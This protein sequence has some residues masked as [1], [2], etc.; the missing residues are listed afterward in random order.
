MKAEFKKSSLGKTGCGLLCVFLMQGERPPP[1]LADFETDMKSHRFEGKEEQYYHTC[2]LGKKRYA[3]LLVAGLGKK[4]DF[5][6]DSLRKAAGACVQHASFLKQ[7]EFLVHAPS[8]KGYEGNSVAQA[9]TE[10]LLLAAYKFTPYKTDKK[11]IFEAKKAYITSEKDWSKGVKDGSIYAGAQNYSRELDEHPA[12]VA[13]PTKIAEEAKTLAKKKKL[14]IR[15]FGKKALEKKKMGGILSVARGSSEPPVLIR[16]EYN[17]GKKLPLYCVVGKGITFDS[18]GIS[19]KPPKGMHEMKYDKSG[20]INVLG[21]MKAVAELN[22]P[23]RVI[24]LMPLSENVPSGSATKPGDIITIYDGKTVEVLNTDAEGRLILADALSYAAEQKPEAII[25]M[26]TLTGAIIVSLGRHAAGLFSNDDKLAKAITE[27]GKETHERV[28]RLPVWP[29]YSEMMESD[30][31]D[32]KNISEKGEAGSITAAAFLKEFV[33]GRKWAHLDIAGV[34]MV[35]EKH[36]YLG[37]KGA[38]GTGVRLVTR[39][40]ARLAEKK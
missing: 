15:V 7:E 32:L 3:H 17:K 5:R 28:W 1:E 6:F 25:D 33:G 14:D 34:E 26:A 4:E 31:A 29:E 16:M 36:P 35:K 18:G 19:L 27:S 8:L 10:G 2:T 37:K 20:A 11:D 13:T 23:I 39:T 21:V 22:L 38:T 30:F 24:G 40:L 12:N 9:I